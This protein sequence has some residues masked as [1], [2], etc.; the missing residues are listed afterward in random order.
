[1]PE[2]LW[3]RYKQETDGLLRE[4]LLIVIWMN[5]GIS[6]YEVGRRL[7]C[8]HSKVLYWK[9]RFDQEGIVG[10]K[11]RSR[12]GKPSKMSKDDEVRMK[13]ILETQEWWKTIWVTDVIRKETGLQYS[14]RHIVRLLHAWGF[15][16][17]IPRKE[18]VE[19]DQK[20]QQRFVKK[21]E[22]YWV[23]SPKIGR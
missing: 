4:R 17:I 10:L 13:Q 14:Q 5:E 20:E 18:H 19:A 15:E 3:E 11:T 7:R 23:R 12:S 9:Y 2:E 16:R 6:S 1:M 21:T 22:S 8:P